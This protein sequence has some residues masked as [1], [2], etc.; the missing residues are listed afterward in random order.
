MFGLSTKGIYGLT[1]VFELALRYDEGPIQIKEIAEGHGIPQH[2]LEQLLVTLRKSGITASFRGT[3]GGYRLADNPAKIRVMDILEA[4]EGPLEVVPKEKGD[5]AVGFFFR[6][7]H[8]AIGKTLD[9]SLAELI[10]KKNDD[11]I[12]FFI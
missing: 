8:D 7:I 3:Q 2:Y 1:A 6:E 5:G 4:L 11:L 12:M 10:E 9:L